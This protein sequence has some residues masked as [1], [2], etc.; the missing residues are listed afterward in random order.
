M[1]RLCSLDGRWGTGKDV[2][3]CHSVVL[4]GM[5]WRSDSVS[6]PKGSSDFF[7]FFLYDGSSNNCL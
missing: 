7:F 4:V 6:W 5:L 2:T 3:V 1:S